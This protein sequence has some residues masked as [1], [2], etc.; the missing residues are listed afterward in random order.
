MCGKAQYH[1]LT[2]IVHQQFLLSA[3]KRGGEEWALRVLGT[4]VPRP[5]RR[6]NGLPG[7]RP[8]RARAIAGSVPA[9]L[10]E[11]SQ[12]SSVR[13][14]DLSLQDSTLS[15]E[16]DTEAEI[17]AAVV[18]SVG[19]L[20]SV[21]F[22]DVAVDFTLEEWRLMDPT[23][24]DLHKDVM[25]ENYR[26]L[27]SL[28]LAVSKPDMI[29]HL[30]N[31][32]GPWA[33]V[34]EITRTPYPGRGNLGYAHTGLCSHRWMTMGNGSKMA[35]ISQCFRHLKLGLPASRTLRKSRFIV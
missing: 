8:S 25:L 11:C 23:Q 10:C 5:L 30:E 12:L 31:G 29:S 13:P 32:K 20:E 16:G 3:D 2:E 33:M 27:A 22:K 14:P 26:N 18:F 19:P 1:R 4:V 6:R 35:T 15:R 7:G 28:G 24:R 9:L 17:M 21:T 34:R